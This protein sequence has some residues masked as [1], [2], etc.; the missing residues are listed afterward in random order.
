MIYPKNY[1]RNW[2]FSCWL[3]PF[4]MGPT[5]VFVFS[6]LGP[7]DLFFCLRFTY[8][9]QG[10]QQNKTKQLGDFLLCLGIVLTWCL[11]F[12]NSAS[13]QRLPSLVVTNGPVVIPAPS[14]L[15]IIYMLLCET[16][17]Y[18]FAIRFPCAFCASAAILFCS[19]H[20][21]SISHR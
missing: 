3:C 18:Y 7:L 5:I 16:L 2:G 13:N 1:A 10:R 9:P 8:L 19:L 11:W 20:R 12:W 15:S 4:H 17:P 21:R 6:V 14:S